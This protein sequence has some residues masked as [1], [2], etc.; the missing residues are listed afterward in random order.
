MSHL[1]THYSSILGGS[2]NTISSSKYS[3]IGA[4][5]N[6]D[7]ESGS[8]SSIIGAGV[9]NTISASDYSAIVA[10]AQSTINSESAVSIIGAGGF[11]Q[12]VTGSSYSIIGAGLSNTINKSK[13]SIIGAGSLNKISGSQWSSIIAGSGSLIPAY[14]NA[15][16]IGS[17]I[18]A[19]QENTTFTEKI[20][21][22]GYI[23]AS[24]HLHWSGQI[25]NNISWIPSH[26]DPATI[27]VIQY[28]AYPTPP[29]GR[30]HGIDILL[31][32]QDGIADGEEKASGGDIIL[33]PGDKDGSLNTTD[34]QVLISGSNLT[35][36]G[37]ISASGDLFLPTGTGSFS[38]LNVDG[39]ISASQNLYLQQDKFIY[40]D[41]D[42]DDELRIGGGSSQFAFLSGSTVMLKL[43]GSAGDA[44]LGI[45]DNN[46]SKELTVRGDI[47]AS[48]Y[49]Y[50]NDE[51]VK[52]SGSL[53]A[54]VSSNTIGTT[55]KGQSSILG[56]YTNYISSNNAIIFHE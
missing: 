33:H 50:G 2:E 7:I 28:N 24:S 44:F 10:G 14:D 54:G 21:A 39:D 52:V 27:E 36:Q 43:S 16:I 38:E 56:G 53:L 26:A 34:G 6:N 25:R 18:T 22:D 30:E 40:W 17:N 12:I 3:I 1:H 51:I 5:Q 49:L 55:G 19:S 13:Y 23:S 37:D 11:N 35:V 29:D 32:G 4:G 15:H 31:R 47:S 48:G 9:G 46:P 45:G 42:G 41:K 20:I 8:Y